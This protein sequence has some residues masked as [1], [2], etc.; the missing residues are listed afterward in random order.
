MLEPKVTAAGSKF[1]AGAACSGGCWTCLLMHDKTFSC[2][3]DIRDVS[4]TEF[5][6]Q[7]LAC[8]NIYLSLV[9]RTVL[10]V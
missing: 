8:T 9:C 5:P 2:Q 3:Q 7:K 6:K 10:G 4:E 1:K